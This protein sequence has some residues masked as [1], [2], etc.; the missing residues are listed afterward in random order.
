[1]G[2]EDAI[3]DYLYANLRWATNTRTWYADKLKP[4][5]RWCKEQGINNLDQLRPNEV[6][7]YTAY[8]QQLTNPQTGKPLSS[9]SIH[10]DVVTIK[11]FLAYCHKEEYITTSVSKRLDVPKKESKVIEVFTSDQIRA[12]AD[13][14]SKECLQWLVYRD[15]AIVYILADTGIRASELCDLTLDRLHLDSDPYIKVTGKGRKEREVGLGRT[16]RAALHKYI[17]RYRRADKAEQHVF[18]GRTFEPLTRSGLDQLLYRLADWAHITGIRV[19]AH[20]YRHTY[21]I[22]YLKQGGDVYKLA[23]LLGH[24]SVSVT[25]VYLRAVSQRDARVGSSVLDTLL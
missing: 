22:N 13:A 6:R 1:M 14:A 25:E 21:A 18:L 5:V 4:F 2:I 15:R 9:N 8:R 7:R 19:S 17:T 24:N 12:M 11:A 10:S 23:R 16:A 20:S 3:E